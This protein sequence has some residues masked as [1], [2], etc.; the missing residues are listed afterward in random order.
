MLVILKSE[1]TRE[2]HERIMER[3]EQ[4]GGRAEL[5]VPKES[6]IVINGCPPQLAR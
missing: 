1:S 4:A 6:V 3:V 2:E 5:H